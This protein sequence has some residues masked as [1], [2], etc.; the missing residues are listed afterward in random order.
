MSTDRPSRG[1]NQ[2]RGLEDFEPGFSFA[3]TGRT[4]SQADVGAFASLTGDLT[5][6]HTNEEYA[7][8]TPYGGCIVHGAFVFSI[9][10]GLTTQTGLLNETLLAFSR[11]ENLRFVRAVFTGDTISVT[12]TLL[13][14]EE[15]GPGR[16][17]LAF[18]TRVRNQRGEIV[19]AYVDK[20]LVARRTGTRVS[21]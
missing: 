11:V 7:R 21:A 17:L 15:K 2:H 14:I 19:L 20:L 10:V 9:S 4:I 18:D 1:V 16:A 8:T 6:L 13:E 12:K 5:A 3:T